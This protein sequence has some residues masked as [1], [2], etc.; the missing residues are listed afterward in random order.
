M[1][2]CRV[3]VIITA[4]EKTDEN[5]DEENKRPLDIS[6]QKDTGTAAPVGNGVGASPVASDIKELSAEQTESGAVAHA[7]RKRKPLI[8]SIASRTTL[9]YFLFAVAILGLLWGVFFFGFYFFYGNMIEREA[10]EVGHSASAAFPKRF[11]DNG[12]NI[13]YKARLS[14]IARHNRPVAIAVFIG[15]DKT[16]YSVNIM[17]DDMGNSLDVNSMLFDSVVDRIDFG[18]V[19]ESDEFCK[20][21]TEYGTFLCCGSIHM[22]ETSTGVQ[23]TYLLIIKPYDMFNS[24]TMKLIY[25]LIFCTVVVLILACICAHIAARHQT[26]QLMDFSQN[27][28][29]IAAGD[30]DVVFSGYGYDEYEN[31]A[32]ALNSAT[33]N[34]QKSER[35]QRDII[36]NVSHDIRTPLT[37][38]NAYAEMLR[39]MPVDEKKR[40]KTADV[41]IS[42]A[43]RLTAL[44]EDVLNY[45]RLQS[46]VNEY[47]YE[48]L[49][50]SDLALA[51]LDRFD[52]MRERDGIKLLNDIDGGLSVE[53]DRQKLEQVLYNLLINAINYCGDDKTVILRVKD[54]NGK[55]RVEVTDHGRGIEESELEA[56]WDRYYRSSHTKRNVVGSGLGLSI[57]KSVLQAHEAE[58]GII[59]EIGKGSTFWF[60][61]ETVKMRGGVKK[62]PRVN[63]DRT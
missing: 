31:L 17:V 62:D 7:K 5:T 58:F 2:T 10:D 24:Q 20:V 50:L 23:K 35:L 1:T 12:M 14:E 51:T 9:N 56:V 55:V 3:F 39:D 16:G 21:S 38:I 27:A 19:F 57:C 59:S 37:M 30:Y 6:E 40:A 42:E 60:E 44:V 8:S 53:G 29:R 47:K 63:N 25:V 34:M 45:S 26:K 48:Q 22:P 61:L 46:G 4:M 18:C 15:D 52:I 54:V 13:I 49:D 43:D 28:K 36:A 32:G 11:D 33:E 41:I